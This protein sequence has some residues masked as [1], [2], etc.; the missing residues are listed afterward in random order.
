MTKKLVFA[1]I[2]LL[3]VAMVALAADVTGKWTYEQPGRNGGPG[4]PASITLKA[5]GANLTGTV[6][7]MGG[8]GM[9]GGGG[10]PGA[11]PGGAPAGGPP[12]ETAISK[13][14]IDGDKISFEVTRETPNGAMTTKYEGVL[15]GAELKLKITR[16][17]QDGTPS[18]TEVVAK[19][20]N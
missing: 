9:G 3:V 17:G 4:R 15:A 7:G 19:K 8:R 2:I 14:K 12:P 1:G 5:D 18:T 13:G 6:S 16:T 10:A 11:A 20:A